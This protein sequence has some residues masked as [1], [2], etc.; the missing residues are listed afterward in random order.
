LLAER[1]VAFTTYDDW[2]R[3][4][5]AEV[6]AGEGERPRTKFTHIDDMLAAAKDYD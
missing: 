4:D 5:A 6:A 2:K 3:I 1:E